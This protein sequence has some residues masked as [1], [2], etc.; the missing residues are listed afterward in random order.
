MRANILQLLR[1]Q[2]DGYISGEEVSRQ[3]AVSR[4]AIWKHIQALKQEGYEIEAHSRKGYRLCGAPDRLLPEEIKSRL[5]TSLLGQAIHY[6]DKLESTNSAA[7]KL[8]IDGCPAGQI[9]VAEEQTA[10]RGRLSRGW[11]SPFA[12]GVWLSLVIRPPFGPEQAPKCTL[13]AAVAV[14]EAIR[15][16]TGVHCGIKW[17][18]DILYG[19]KKLVGILTEMSA[20]MDAIDFVVIGIGVNVN[21]HEGQLPLELVATAT[22]LAMIAGRDFSRLEL[23]ATILAELEQLYFVAIDS[24]FGPV[25]DKWRQ[26][27]VTLGREVQVL[28]GEA[29]FIGMAKDIDDEGC[30]LVATAE[31]LQKVVAGDVS[32]RGL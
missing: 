2:P 16:V 9:V 32:V 26:Q 1:Q 12:Q 30:L 7:K 6:V 19:D 10:G 27:S 5:K 18:N 20:Q 14:N 11:F 28:A 25:L 17:P 13:L 22:S 24:G 29:S 21:I 4:T 31:G 3:L 8:A 15:K 23:L